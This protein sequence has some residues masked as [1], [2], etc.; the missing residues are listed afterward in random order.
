MAAV[1]ISY[2]AIFIL[3]LIAGGVIMRLSYARFKNDTLN[4]NAA[5]IDRIKE[6]IDPIVAE[7]QRYALSVQNN[8]YMLDIISRPGLSVMSY[9][10]LMPVIKELNSH[11]VRRD[12]IRDIY[13]YCN[14]SDIMIGDTIY[15][16]YQVYT[17][18]LVNCAP[19]YEEWKK[20]YLFTNHYNE[21]VP[22]VADGHGSD[23]LNELSLVNTLYGEDDA[24]VIGTVIIRL[25]T[26]KIIRD[27]FMS[28]FS[29]E[30][31]FY[32]LNN[33]KEPLISY[34][35]NVSDIEAVPYIDLKGDGRVETEDD[36]LVTFNY[37]ANNG[38]IYAAATPTSVAMESI[39]PMHL[40]FAAVILLYIA[41][42]VLI[43]AL[44]V[45]KSYMSVGRIAKR[46]GLK[47][48]VSRVGA[49]DII[50]RINTADSYRKELESLVSKY[51]DEEKNNKLL[52]FIRGSGGEDIKLTEKYTRVAA[53]RLTDGGIFDMQKKED[54]DMAMLCVINILS[55]LLES[56]CVCHIAR[57]NNE[58]LLCLMNYSMDDE[59]FR[60]GLENGVFAKTAEVLNSGFEI[61][62][63][64][65]VSSLG[66]SPGRLEHEVE[67]AFHYRRG[68]TESVML[69]Y[70]DIE[71]S[72]QSEMYYY[73]YEYEE[74]ILSCIS[75]GNEKG[76]RGILDELKEKNILNGELDIQL[77]ICFYYDLLS[78]YKKAAERNRYDARPI[79]SLLINMAK[80]DASVKTSIDELCGALIDMCRLSS[81]IKHHDIDETAAVVDR[82][83]A[84]NFADPDLNLNMIADHFGISRQTISKK[85]GASFGVKVSD[86]IH[87]V[88]IRESKKL[89]AQSSLNIS[90]I[91][92]LVGY[93]DS[94]SFIRV[95]KKVTGITPGQYRKNDSDGHIQ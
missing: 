2:A 52:A 81:R 8:D 49:E 45:R 24:E 60:H 75:S 22:G 82:Y 43:V 29:G 67:S 95:F 23:V 6:T 64:M 4:Y 38:W 51:S 36:R 50:N 40:Y 5:G 91:A 17:D 34:N 65:I 47:Q 79:N 31:S 71:H 11:L 26:S 28:G 10:E 30:S 76:L 59:E 73:P 48:K 78:T 53:V 74:N 90:D 85:F 88:R 56:L 18:K 70:D 57:E 3:S 16:T 80:D 77:K 92:M 72:G 87:E 66:S 83:I 86:H 12:Y 15:D 19:G 54:K 93:A 94:N 35:T 37:S 69:Y 55:E 84:E 32:V 13:I 62:I 89:L 61:S 9:D 58:M 21:F 44:G 25:D 41:A 68:G 14:A 63:E 42:G 46:L 27:I 7:E 1:A 33:I 39:A 20:E